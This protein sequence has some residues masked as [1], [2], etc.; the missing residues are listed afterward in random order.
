[1]PTM[2]DIRSVLRS[3]REQKTGDVFALA[4]Q[5]SRDESVDPDVLAAAVAAAGMDED[6][7]VDLVDLLRRRDECRAKAGTLAAAEKELASVRDAIK[8]Q[9]E[10]LE[11]SEKRYR[12]AVEPLIFQEEAA[13]SRVSEAASAASALAAP[14]NLPAEINA[15]VE[16]TR[17]SLHDAGVEVRK[18]ENEMDLQERR[19]EDGL[20]VVDRDG[21]FERVSQYYDDPARRQSMRFAVQEAVEGIRGGRHRLSEAKPRLADAVAA[22]DAAKVAFDAAE[23]AAR[24]F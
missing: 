4:R 11:E 19:V 5:L 8:R 13:A 22:R 6:A 17:K 7:L 10:A 9:R 24:E 16:A 3:R 20:T 2:L 14:A 1:M 23:K 12:R 15:G 18:I 21:G